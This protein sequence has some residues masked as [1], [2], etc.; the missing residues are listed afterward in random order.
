MVERQIDLPN[1]IVWDAL[2][3]PVLVEGW[4]HPTAGLFDGEVRERTE[5]APG[6]AAVLA[7]RTDEFGELRFELTER[8][9]GTRGGVTELRVRVA[10]A[11]DPRFRAPIVA[12]WL[13]RL[14]QLEALLRGHPVDW[15]TWKRDSTPAYEHYLDEQRRAR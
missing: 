14:D 8:E 9:G 3:D 13:L 7:V 11:A 6:A 10:S 15:A 1:S 5:P 4:L 12:C 2:I